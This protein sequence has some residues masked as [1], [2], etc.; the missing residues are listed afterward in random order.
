MC[1]S[2]PARTYAST[3]FRSAGVSDR[4]WSYIADRSV[5]ALWIGAARCRRPQNVDFPLP[6][7]PRTATRSPNQISASNR[8]IKPVSSRS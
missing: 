3:E 7:A 1:L 2:E 6:F 8:P 5:L 4:V